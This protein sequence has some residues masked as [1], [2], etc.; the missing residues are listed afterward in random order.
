MKKE[1]FICEASSKIMAA[2]V[3]SHNPLGLLPSEFKTFAVDN[4]KHLADELAAQ[5]IVAWPKL[6]APK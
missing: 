1:D 5:K 3:S 6:D 4:A 2:L